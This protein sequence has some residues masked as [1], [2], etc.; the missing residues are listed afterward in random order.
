[1]RQAGSEFGY[2]RLFGSTGKIA[3]GEYATIVQHPNGRQ[4]HIAIRNNKITVY[5]YD[6]DLA[7]TEAEGNNFL[8]FSTAPSGH[9]R[10]GRGCGLGS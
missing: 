9:A 2:L 6:S 1:L 10:V 7:Q 4:K 5:V 8:Y 3:R